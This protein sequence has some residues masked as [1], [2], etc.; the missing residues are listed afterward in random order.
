[1]PDSQCLRRR[2]NGNGQNG[3]EPAEFGFHE[4][5]IRSG[6]GKN[7][8]A[9]DQK[10]SAG[11]PQTFD[12][13]ATQRKQHVGV[14][15]KVRLGFVHHPDRNQQAAVGRN[16]DVTT[17]RK[18]EKKAKKEEKKLDMVF[19]KKLYLFSSLPFFHIA[20]FAMRQIKF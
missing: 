6:S 14:E 9:P 19:L 4:L 11:T 18:E 7:R 1:M 15:R 8:F 12:F 3:P 20:S 17:Q 10:T 5:K 16:T 13:T 2:F